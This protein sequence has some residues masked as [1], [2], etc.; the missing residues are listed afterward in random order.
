MDIILKTQVLG[1]DAVLC[2]NLTVGGKIKTKK[3]RMV[4]LHI[5]PH[6]DY[7]GPPLKV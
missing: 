6:F 3:S 5:P 4:S 7:C 1:V 2:T